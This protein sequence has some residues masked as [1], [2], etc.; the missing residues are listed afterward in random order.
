MRPVPRWVAP[1]ALGVAA[2]SL[3]LNGLFLWGLREPQRWL[4]PVLLRTLDR[5]EAEDTRLRYQLRVPA[6]TPLR[7]DIP[8]DERLSVRVDT[9]LPIR[10]RIQLPIRSPFGNYTVSVP[11]RADVPIRTELPVRIRHT[12]RLRTATQDEIVLPLEIRVRDLPLDLLRES[13][14]Q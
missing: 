11:V 10:T 5:M 12:L 3:L 13:L 9:E 8:I 6:G 2:L 14:S 7:A 4:A 1:A